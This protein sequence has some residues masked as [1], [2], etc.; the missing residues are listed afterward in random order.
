MGASSPNCCRRPVSSTTIIQLAEAAR[1]ALLRRELASNRLLVQPL[2]RVQR[3]GA[4]GA[5]HRACRR[6]ARMTRY[7]SACITTYIISKCESVSDLLEVNL[8]LK[9]AGLYRP[10]AP[11]E[12][13]IMVV[14][15]FETIGDLERA[16]QIMREWLALPEVRAAVGAPRLPGSDG[17]LFGFQ[18]GWRLPDLG[19]EPEPGHARAGRCLR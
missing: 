7:G 11:A 18:Q 4:L 17:R 19:V 3:R 5:G 1:V 2:H 16:P 12:A 15:L 14:P 8:L 10:D 13:A 9:E 6:G